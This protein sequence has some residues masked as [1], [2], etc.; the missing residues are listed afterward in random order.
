M[1]TTEGKLK[2][3]DQIGLAVLVNAK[4]KLTE[5]WCW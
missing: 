3:V 4:G 5:D 1:V 2:K